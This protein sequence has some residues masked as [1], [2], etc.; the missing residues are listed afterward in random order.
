MKYTRNMLDS[1][2]RASVAHC[3]LHHQ[4][5][6]SICPK[7]TPQLVTANRVNL[8]DFCWHYCVCFTHMLPSAL[9]TILHTCWTLEYYMSLNLSLYCRHQDKVTLYS[10][11]YNS[12]EHHSLL[13]LRGA[14][15]TSSRCSYIILSSSLSQHLCSI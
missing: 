5:Y 1:T 4:Q 9:C 7:S 3:V 6:G 10:T 8:L 15:V 2:S 14:V 12:T 13:S 11:S